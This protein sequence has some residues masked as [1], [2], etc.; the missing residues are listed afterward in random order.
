V[1]L[2]HFAPDHVGTW[3]WVATF[4]TGSKVAQ[5]GGGSSGSYFDGA[6]GAFRVIRSN[7]VG[8]D[9]RG[10]GF[11]RYVGAHHLQFVQTKE[12]FLKAGADSPENFLAYADFDG[13][14]NIGKRRKTWAAHAGDYATGDPTWKNGKGKNIIGG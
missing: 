7:K 4:A 5:N 11:L 1:W 12:Y 8:R 6:S 9:H 14:L 3:S 13:T 2:C 10:K